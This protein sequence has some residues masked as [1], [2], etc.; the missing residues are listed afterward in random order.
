M[1]DFVPW[2][3][4]I[5]SL[6]LASEDEENEGEMANLVHKFGAW[7]RKRGVSFKWATDATPE[8]VG[9]V[10]QHSTDIGLE[11]QAIVIMDSPKMGFHG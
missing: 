1:E 6:P 10:D 5:S 2:V 7:K 3:A 9:D 11:E 8:V 4:P